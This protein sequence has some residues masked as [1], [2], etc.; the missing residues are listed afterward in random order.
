MKKSLLRKLCAISLA[1]VTMTGASVGGMTVYAKEAAQT[2]V[3]ATADRGVYKSFEWRTKKVGK[4][5]QVVIEKYKG[6]ADNVVIPETI[7]GMKVTEIG[8]TAFR[9]NTNIKRAISSTAST[10]EC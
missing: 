9:N 3:S 7:E 2:T 10:T 1:M 8:L 4:E 5:T 6:K